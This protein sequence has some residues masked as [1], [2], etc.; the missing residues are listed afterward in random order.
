MAPG[1]YAWN[2]SFGFLCCEP[3]ST[4]PVACISCGK[5]I[6][7]STSE[8]TRSIEHKDGNAIQSAEIPWNFYFVNYD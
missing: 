7:Y 1:C 3:H 2:V 6:P 8:R 5:Q 4:R